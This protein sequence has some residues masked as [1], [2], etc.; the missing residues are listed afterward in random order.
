[1]ECRLAQG[2][3]AQA[4]CAWHTTQRCRCVHTFDHVVLTCRH[5]KVCSQ[6]GRFGHLQAGSGPLDRYLRLKAMQRESYM[7]FFYEVRKPLT[8]CTTPDVSRVSH[9][10]FTAQMPVRQC[11]LLLWNLPAMPGV[12]DATSSQFV[13]SPM[14]TDKIQLLSETRKTVSVR[15]CWYLVAGVC[16]FMTYDGGLTP[17]TWP[18]TN[19]LLSQFLTHAA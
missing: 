6:L 11:I 7:H 10:S 18:M 9:A 19:T 14:T 4:C 2:P 13:R 16:T 1:L 12:N 3:A 8:C 15:A 5:A 17:Q